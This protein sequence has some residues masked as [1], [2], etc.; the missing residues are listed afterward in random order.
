MSDLAQLLKEVPGENPGITSGVAYIPLDE[1]IPD[2][3]TGFDAAAHAATMSGEI[4]VENPAR[5]DGFEQVYIANAAK[6]CANCVG[7]CCRAFRLGTFI[8]D[9]PAS[10]RKTRQTMREDKMALAWLRNGKRRLLIKKY[11]QYR[12]VKWSGIEE[13]LRRSIEKS[14]DDIYALKFFSTRLLPA[15]NLE[16]HPDFAIMSEE[17][18][19]HTFRC[20]EFDEEK[21]RCKAHGIRPALCRRYICLPA[22]AGMVPAEDKMTFGVI[23]INRRKKYEQKRRRRTGKTS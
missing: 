19:T 13:I 21:H 10:L 20:A 15:R 22:T 17:Q 12:G 7:H 16:F 6:A 2:E 14:K 1:A 11:G 4:H 9:I 18:K 3:V 5:P 8:D 23:E